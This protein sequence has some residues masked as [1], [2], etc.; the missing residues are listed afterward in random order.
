MSR[1]LIDSH[2]DDDML[3]PAPA[4]YRV[5]FTVEGVPVGKAR[6]RVTRNGTY[7]P[8]KTRRY[9]HDVRTVAMQAMGAL[10]PCRDAVH[11]SL[12]VFL[13]VPERFS[14]AKRAAALAGLVYPVVRPDLDNFEKAVTDALNGVVYHDDSQICDVVKS[15]RYSDRPRVVIECASINGFSTYELQPA[16]RIRHATHPEKAHG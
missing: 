8:K 1:N 14:K 4:T 9:E 15:K 16:R 7:T 5:S 10:R 11:V 13:P 3:T 12:V 2:I 6:A